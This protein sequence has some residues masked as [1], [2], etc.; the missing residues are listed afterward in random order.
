M[1]RHGVTI[2]NRERRFQGHTDVPLSN[3]GEL[4]AEITATFLADFPITSCYSSDLAR[5][6]HTALPIAGRLGIKAEPV[7]QLREASKGSL[8]GKYRNPDTGLIGDESHYH[9]ENEI[10]ERPPGGESM[11][12]L[13][14]RSRAFVTRLMNDE[15]TL[16][17]GDILIV[18][19]GGTMRALLSVMLDLPVPAARSFHFDNCSLTTV[20]FRGDLPPLLTRYNQI[21]HLNGFRAE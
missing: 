9:D 20:V 14:D 8:E 3:D 4:Q 1:V 5:A 6:F 13:A 19:H 7:W 10:E 15:G 17:P 18:S 12:D 16:P 2:W 21:Q 11:L